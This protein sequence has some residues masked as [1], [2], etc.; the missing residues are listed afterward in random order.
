[1]WFYDSLIWDKN[2]KKILSR[3]GTLLHTIC[4]RWKFYNLVKRLLLTSENGNSLL[5]RLKQS[6][7]RNIAKISESV[8]SSARKRLAAIKSKTAKTLSVENEALQRFQDFTTAAY[9]DEEF[10]AEYESL[11]YEI[12]ASP[13]FKS[14]KK[15]RQ[16]S[17]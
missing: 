5:K 17:K 6:R 3:H 9:T 16:T 4:L 10:L 2:D 7:Y 14:N 13:E 15:L 1:M 12:A 11:R 8:V